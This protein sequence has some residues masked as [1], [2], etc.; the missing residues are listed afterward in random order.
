MSTPGMPPAA[1]P[2]GNIQCKGKDRF[3]TFDQA[4]KVARDMCRRKDGG[5]QAYRCP[6]CE[7]G[8]H[9]GGTGLRGQKRQ[10]RARRLRIGELKEQ[11]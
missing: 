11:A 1:R 6:H 2:N 4:A 9:I 3:D 7:G 8:Y 5:L 10:A